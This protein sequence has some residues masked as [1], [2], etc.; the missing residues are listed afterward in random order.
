M[1]PQWLSD[2]AEAVASLPRRERENLRQRR[3]ILDTALRL[4]SENGYHNVSMQQIAKQ[5]EFGVGTIYK[6]FANKQDLYKILVMETAEK[7]QRAVLE[8]LEQEPNPF[9]AI[10]AYIEVQREL[11]FD[12]AP[13]VG[14]YYSETKGAYFNIR[15]GFDEELLKMRDQRIK[16]L[17]SVFESGI[18]QEIFRDADPYHMALAL[19]GIIDAFL[20]RMMED[21]ARF[22]KSDELS[23]AADIFLRGVMSKS[24]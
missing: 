18:K 12:N 1:N 2:G 19:H 22:L 11:L 16:K 13:V 20:F 7:W 5:A 8:V 23:F 21:P 4:F 15:S 17:A 14:L 6:F 3:E 24:S 9:E 10:K